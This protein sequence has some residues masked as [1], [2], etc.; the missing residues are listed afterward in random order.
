MFETA[1]VVNPIVDLV[2]HMFYDIESRETTRMSALEHD[3][4]HFDKLQEFGD[5]QNRLFYEQIKL[6]SP[7]NM[8]VQDST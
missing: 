2:N 8:P 4:R 1:V 5:P 7:Y 3:L 6:I